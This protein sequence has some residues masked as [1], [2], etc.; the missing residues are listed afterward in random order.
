MQA[1]VPRWSPDGTQIAF[2]GREPGKSWEIYIVPAE[3]GNPEAVT[4][5]DNDDLDPTWSPS[6]EE[7]AFGGS[8]PAA[9]SKKHPIQILNLKSRAV[10]TLPD[11]GEYYSPNWSPDG[12]W[13][14]A[15]NSNA[16]GLALYD[17][18]T[19]QWGELTKV[20]ASNANWSR[21]GECVYFNDSFDLKMPV[22]RVC[23]K[24]RKAQLVVNLAK[25]GTLATGTFGQWTGVAPDGSILA[26]RDNSL[27]EIYALEA[28]LP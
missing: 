15:V 18:S 24:D 23:L 6:G 10:E 17:F 7:L 9:V 5:G 25:G 13:L 14:V 28:E 3:G 1:G 4:G 11:S 26:V 19:H 16:H 27:E 8:S 21:D 2:A 12:R 22:Y 20:S